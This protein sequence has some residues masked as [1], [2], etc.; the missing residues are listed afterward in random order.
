MQNIYINKYVIYAIFGIVV[1]T[2][3]CEHDNNI[4]A[5]LSLQPRLSCSWSYLECG[6]LSTLVYTTIWNFRCFDATPRIAIVAESSVDS[7]AWEQRQKDADVYRRTGYHWIWLILNHHIWVSISQLVDA[8]WSTNI[9]DDRLY[10]EN[11]SHSFSIRLDYRR[12]VESLECPW[13]HSYFGARRFNNVSS[14]GGYSDR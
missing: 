2:C 1:C 6:T 4:S 12:I 13:R 7:H 11:V 9:L 14:Y 5:M 3:N 8:I 10:L